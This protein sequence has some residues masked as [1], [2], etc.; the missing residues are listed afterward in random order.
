MFNWIRTQFAKDPRDQFPHSW[1]L[2]QD[3]SGDPLPLL[4]LT[5]KTAE[6]VEIRDGRTTHPT[7]GYLAL[8]MPRDMDVLGDDDDLAITN[9]HHELFFAMKARRQIDKAATDSAGHWTGRHLKVPLPSPYLNTASALGNAVRA[10]DLGDLRRHNYASGFAAGT[11]FR[12]GLPKFAYSDGKVPAFASSDADGRR[13][14]SVKAQRETEVAPDRT[15]VGAIPSI[16]QEIAT[17]IRFAYEARDVEGI[18]ELSRL[19]RVRRQDFR[20]QLGTV[21]GKAQDVGS[22]GHYAG[23][24]LS[25]LW[26][27]RQGEATRFLTMGVVARCHRCGGDTGYATNAQDAEGIND[28]CDAVGIDTN[29]FTERVSDMIPREFQRIFVAQWEASRRM[30]PTPVRR[31]YWGYLES[32]LREAV[33]AMKA[34]DDQLYPFICGYSEAVALGG[35]GTQSGTMQPRGRNAAE[36]LPRIPLWRRVVPPMFRNQRKIGQ[37]AS[38]SWLAAQIIAAW[39]NQSSDQTRELLRR[40]W[41]FASWELGILGG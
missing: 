32:V 9:D 37:F 11:A 31:E 35:D 2:V 25:P 24:K 21:E 26:H 36:D 23:S 10:L 5:I 12:F 19:C 14:A 38:P 1:Q 7:T 15:P 16:G 34:D 40:S 4:G 20:D 30:L 18:S 13:A 3:D 27:I 6:P 17:Q 28:V 8:T 39:A 22:C 29:R 41:K 33:E